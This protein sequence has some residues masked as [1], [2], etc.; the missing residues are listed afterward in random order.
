MLFNKSTN[1]RARIFQHL[2][3]NQSYF[4]WSNQRLAKKFNCGERTI[5]TIVNKLNPV[6]E[7]YLKSLR[8]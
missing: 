4:K 5:S 2:L 7:E 3:A 8:K 1:M 6:K